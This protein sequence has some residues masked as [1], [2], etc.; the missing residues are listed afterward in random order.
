MK[1]QIAPHT[2]QRAIERGTTEEEIIE[3]LQSGV[4]IL[5]KIGRLGNQKCF[6]STVIELENTMKKRKWTCII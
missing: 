3:V 4:N 1:I 6:R 5:G 2:L